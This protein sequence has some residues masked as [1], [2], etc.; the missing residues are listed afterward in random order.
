MELYSFNYEY[1]TMVLKK[2]IF[3]FLS[4]LFSGLIVGQVDLSG[5]WQGIIQ[6]DGQSIEKSTLLY[7]NFNQ[8]GTALDGKMRDEIVG[9]D[10]YA[11]KRLKGTVLKNEITFNQ[12]IIEKQKQNAQS[13]WCLLSGTLS[14]N[15]SSG[16][17]IGTFKSTDCKRYTG[18]IILYKS[19]AEFSA[20][21]QSPL[22]HAWFKQFV[23]DY[24]KGLNAPFIRAIER[25]NFQFLPIYF[26]TDK[27]DLNPDFVPF[28]IKMIRVVDGHSDLRIKVTGHTD[29]DGSDAYNFELSKR[30]AETLID[31]FVQHGLSKDKIVI[32]FKGES[33][34]VDNNSTTEG[35]QRNRRVDFSFI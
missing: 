6:L 10:F 19:T 4:C 1:V 20:T 27:A 33:L 16:Y 24:K 30:R 17:L 3:C 15:D 8:K 28:L 31:F 7:A 34:P 23:T 9:K 18:K 11:V 12:T 26:E 29:A 25:K 35:K 14:Y 22:S 21:T 2:H 5:N 32:D 13:N